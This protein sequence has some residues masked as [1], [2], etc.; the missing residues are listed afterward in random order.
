[1]ARTIPIVMK[2]GFKI[3]IVSVFKCAVDRVVRYDTI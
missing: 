2:F 3:L 1:M